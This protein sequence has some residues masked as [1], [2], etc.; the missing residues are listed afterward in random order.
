MKRFKENIML[1]NHLSLFYL[2]DES[3]KSKPAV[4]QSGKSSPDDSMMLTPSSLHTERQKIV[5]SS[6]ESSSWLSAQLIHLDL[7]SDSSILRSSLTEARW[8]ITMRE[9]LLMPKVNYRQS[10]LKIFKNIEVEPTLLMSRGMLTYALEY[11]FGKK[12]SLFPYFLCGNI[13]SWPNPK[14][15]G[16]S[17]RTSSLNLERTTVL[18]RSFCR[19]KTE[20][21]QKLV[22]VVH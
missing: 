11:S 10:T 3:T 16:P 19:K 1:L 2:R 9:V 15:I 18:V 5:S 6:W 20:K 22:M 7:L 21:H 8:F 12:A 4:L 17:E 13:W 14:R